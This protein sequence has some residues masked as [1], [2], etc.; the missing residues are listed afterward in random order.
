MKHYIIYFQIKLLLPIIVDISQCVDLYTECRF[1]QDH[2]DIDYFRHV[3][4]RTCNFCHHPG[5]FQDEYFDRLSFGNYRS[6]KKLQVP[7]NCFLVSSSF[8]V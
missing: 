5:E 8:Q 7:K 6:T 1:V 3:C 4:P 2:C